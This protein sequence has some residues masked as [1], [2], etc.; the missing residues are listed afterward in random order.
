MSQADV[1]RFVADLKSNED[2][3]NEVT[4]AASGIG[5]V[6]EIAKSHG[7]DISVDEARDYIRSRASSDLS[8]EQLDAIAGGKG[9]HSVSN[10]TAAVNVQTAVNVTTEAGVAETTEAVAA[11]AV[12]VIVLT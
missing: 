7:Y 10:V 8:D 5:S 3:R 6:V 12:A 11:E 1:D 2:L 4:G 9:H